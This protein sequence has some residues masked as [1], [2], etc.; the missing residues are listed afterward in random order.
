[1]R[2]LLQQYDIDTSLAAS[3]GAKAF[4]AYLA[5]KAMEYLKAF[6]S[7]PPRSYSLAVHARY[8]DSFGVGIVQA[9]NARM[10]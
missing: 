9:K 10:R 4:H 3:Y 7:Q 2:K 5:G 8:T 1:M 6:W